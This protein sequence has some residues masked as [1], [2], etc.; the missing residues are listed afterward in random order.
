MALGLKETALVINEF[1]DCIYLLYIREKLVLNQLQNVCLI[2]LN[3]TLT[4][5]D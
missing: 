1:C 3:Y 2:I 5:L 4:G